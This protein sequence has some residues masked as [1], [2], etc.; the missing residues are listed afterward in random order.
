MCHSS[1]VRGVPR[2]MSPRE[3]FLVGTGGERALADVGVPNSK[4]PTTTT[5]EHVFDAVSCMIASGDHVL[6]FRVLTFPIIT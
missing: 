1:S 2:G 3:P 5:I 6:A 4:K